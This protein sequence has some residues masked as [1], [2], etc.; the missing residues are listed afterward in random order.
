MRIARYGEICQ[1][2]ERFDASLGA[3]QP[4]ERVPPQHL[5]DLDIQQMWCV[6][7]LA[8]GKKPLGETSSGRGT[9]QYLDQRRRV[10]DDQRPS[11]SAR[12]ALAGES[13]GRTEVR[14]SRRARS[15]VTVGRSAMSRISRRR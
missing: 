15:S 1:I 14:P 3:E 13:V 11:R 10:D 8:R 9:E 5:C 7:C 4:R 6:Q 12:T 2:L